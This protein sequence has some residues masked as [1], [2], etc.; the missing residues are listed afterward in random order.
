MDISDYRAKINDI[1]DKLVKLLDDR[2]RVSEDIARYKAENDMDIV[3]AVREREHLD[4]IMEAS[5]EDMAYYNKILFATLMEESEDHQ[6]MVI[7]GESDLVKDIRSAIEG[8]PKTFPDQASVACQGVPGAYSQEACDRFFKIPKIM[9][10]NNFRGV[11]AAIES[12]LCEYGVLPIENSTA[13]SVNQVYDLLREYDYHIVKSMKVKIDH[14]LLVNKGATKQT[15]REIR[16]HEQALAQCDTYIRRE[17]PD[18]EIIVC[19]DTAGAASEVA[20]S[21]RNDIAAIASKVSG[22]Y[23]GLECM[24]SMIQDNNNNYTRFICITKDLV[25]YPGANITSFICATNHKPGSL[26][27]VMAKINAAGIN[28]LKLESRPIPESDFDFSFYFDIQES[29]YSENFVRMMSQ[30]EDECKMF[31]YLGSH[32]EV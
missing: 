18:A 11:F 8:S 31:K 23:Y 20:E 9:Y 5:A 19:E 2:M 13:G 12:G 15:I 3:D 32:I 4:E 14:C 30:L 24:D 28:I 17:F 26:Y 27:R 7:G 10:S 21:G 22:D 1:D 29:V 25:I 16:S 6:R